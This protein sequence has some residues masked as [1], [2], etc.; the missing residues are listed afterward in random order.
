MDK[1]CTHTGTT[2][3]KCI[4]AAGIKSVYDMTLYYLWNKTYILHITKI[5]TLWFYILSNKTE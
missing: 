2:K 1:A 3:T 4:K 5:K